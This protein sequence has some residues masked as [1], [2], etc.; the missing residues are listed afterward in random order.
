MPSFVPLPQKS[1]T[2]Q[3]RLEAATPRKVDFCL[4]ENQCDVRLL[5]MCKRTSKLCIQFLLAFLVFRE[6]G[7]SDFY[8]HEPR[9]WKS[10]SINEK[11][12]EQI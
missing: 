6:I 11:T 5:R 3:L 12:V 9:N 7:Q 1:H 8:V 10:L 2:I 4:N